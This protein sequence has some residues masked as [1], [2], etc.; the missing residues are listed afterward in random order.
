MPR[1][2]AL[3]PPLADALTVAHQK[4]IVHRDLKPANVM[5]ATDGRMKGL[6]F[7]LARV[8][9]RLAT[10][11]TIEATRQLLTCRVATSTTHSQSQTTSRGLPT[12][13]W[14]AVSTE[15]TSI[16]DCRGAA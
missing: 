7:G 5:V 4:H 3:A 16:H 9:G 11:E 1:F 14:H 8:A 10:H 13:V 6:D 15:V 12:P 2:L